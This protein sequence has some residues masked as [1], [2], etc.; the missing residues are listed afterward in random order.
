MT[1]MNDSHRAELLTE[2]LVDYE[3]AGL[4][5]HRSA[6]FARD[7]IA[8]AGRGKGFTAGQRK[9]VM[10]IIDEP[11]PAAKNP[12]RY[13]AIRAAATVEGLK[14]RTRDILEDFAV[15][16][17]NGWDLSEKQEA[18][19]K[20][21]LAEV[22]ETQANGPWVPTAPQLDDIRSCVMLAN[23]YNDFYLQSHPGLSSAIQKGQQLMTYMSEDL[24]LV[25]ALTES[26][27]DEWCMNKL[28]KQF[29]TPLT[30]LAQPKHPAGEM[31]FTVIK[32]TGVLPVALAIIIVAEPTVNKHGQI[33]YPTIING[34]LENISS[35]R[36]A[37][38]MPRITPDI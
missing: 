31:R 24:G 13:E 29:K 22:A 4:K 28:F 5:E 30:E 32:R 16:F 26:V 36:I 2:R 27:F 7:M 1:R 35:E 14:T 23:R 6:C 34:A 33:C 21:L 38:R 20:K 18:F 3:A 19:L 25:A 12:E 9:W 15:K 8:R 37:K 10:S 17:F 11:L